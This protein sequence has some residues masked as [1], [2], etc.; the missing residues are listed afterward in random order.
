MFGYVSHAGCLARG[1]R[2]E[3]RAT[4]ERPCCSHG[5]ATEGAGGHHREFA[6]HPRTGGLDRLAWSRV[7]GS[8]RLEQ[9]EDVFRT[10]GRPEREAPMVVFGQKSA[11]LHGDEARVSDGGKNHT[12][13]PFD[14]IAFALGPNGPFLHIR[15]YEKN[16]GHKSWVFVSG[17]GDRI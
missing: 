17:S 10:L 5:V 4:D 9:V 15:E 8:D 13:R 3:A 12:S 11:A 1:V 7:D 14:G 16:P 2:G 6:A